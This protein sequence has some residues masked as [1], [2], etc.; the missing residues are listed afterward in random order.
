MTSDFQLVDDTMGTIVSNHD[1]WS[2]DSS[3]QILQV[4]LQVN[5]VL[6]DSI[7]HH[8]TCATTCKH[9]FNGV[10]WYILVFLDCIT[11]KTAEQQL[12]PLL[13]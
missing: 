1:L 10:Q 2:G 8:L 3:S 5:G 13:A 9:R 6:S 11:W 4:D 12:C 7:L